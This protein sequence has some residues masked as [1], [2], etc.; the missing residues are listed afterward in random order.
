MSELIGNQNWFFGEPVVELTCLGIDF[1][2]K[3]GDLA[4]GGGNASDFFPVFGTIL[5]WSLAVQ[6]PDSAPLSVRI[7]WRG[8]EYLLHL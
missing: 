2:E 7:S 8:D 1:D 5:S 4:L 6:L 3:R